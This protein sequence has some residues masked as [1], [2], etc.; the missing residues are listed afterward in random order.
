MK[1][2]NNLE[3]EKWAIQIPTFAKYVNKNSLPK[4][5]SRRPTHTHTCIR[6]N[7]GKEGDFLLTAPVIDQI[8]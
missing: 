8:Y 1:V 6:W 7:D 2:G 4:S 5:T 3:Q